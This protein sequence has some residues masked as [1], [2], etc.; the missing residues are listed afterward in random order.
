MKKNKSDWPISWGDVKEAIEKVE[1][2]SGGGAGFINYKGGVDL[3]VDNYH[4]SLT[5]IVCGTESGLNVGDEI[6]VGIVDASD[7]TIAKSYKFNFIVVSNSLPFD[8]ADEGRPT[9]AVS[10]SGVNFYEYD[11]CKNYLY[12]L[13]MRDSFPITF[14]FGS[15]PGSD[16]LINGPATGVQ[17][18]FIRIYKANA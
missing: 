3:D 10:C 14:N 9:Y 1:N 5:D 2:S 15:F 13:G 18:A 7:S 6:E 17:I 8:G 4:F 12:I 16:S 11:E